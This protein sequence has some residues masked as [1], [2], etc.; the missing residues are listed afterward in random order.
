MDSPAV[1]TYNYLRIAIV[2]AVLLLGVSIVVELL[3]AEG[4]VCSS[5]P[6]CG[7]IS[8]FYYTPVHAVFVGT[9][10]A[11][12]VALIAIKGRPGWE[13]TLLNVAGALTPVVAFAPT[14][15]SP[16]TSEAAEA[17]ERGV[18]AEYVPGIIN[19]VWALLVVGALALVL[20]AVL[21]VRNGELHGANAVGIGV[22]A[23]LLVAFAVWFLVSG[24]D[25]GGAKFLD[26]AHYV[27]AI[28]LFGIITLVVE[29][30]ARRS[31]ERDGDRLLRPSVYKGTYRS[32]AVAMGATIIGA[33]VLFF[34]QSSDASSVPAG[35]LFWVEAVLL[36]LFIVF[37]V[38]QTLDYWK[39]GA[40]VAVE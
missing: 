38:L 39:D 7:S 27:A 12:G 32:I 13:D 34:L 37:W 25:L 18:P 16:A 21:A 26:L 22:F 14:P 17:V 31:G 4:T 28:P 9:L 1:R 33:I 15:L 11:V 8:A 10:V 19:N 29:I 30:N 24:K 36:L 6:T 3:R 40:P 23:V 5:I 35:W 2:A 20:A